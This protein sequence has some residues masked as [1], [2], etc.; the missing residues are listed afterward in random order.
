[1]P[2]FGFIIPKL[3]ASVLTAIFAGPCSADDVASCIAMLDAVV[4][5]QGG[6]GLPISSTEDGSKYRSWLHLAAPNRPKLVTRFPWDLV[7]EATEALKRFERFS[8][9]WR[10]V[11]I[12]NIAR[13]HCTSI[14]WQS[15][16]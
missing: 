10:C 6:R 2:R 13:M 5:S 8:E 12:V 14:R 1:L 11:S 7:C 15:T 3:A 4:C 9:K 16:I